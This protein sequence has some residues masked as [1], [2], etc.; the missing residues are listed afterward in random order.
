MTTFIDKKNQGN[1]IYEELANV[2]LGERA[3]WLENLVKDALLQ[4]R[5]E[6]EEEKRLL[7]QKIQDIRMVINGRDKTAFEVW[8]E[9]NRIVQNNPPATP[10]SSPLLIQ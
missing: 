7:R 4:Q 1:K 8:Q 5:I 9:V 3:D 6:L 10:E 2:P